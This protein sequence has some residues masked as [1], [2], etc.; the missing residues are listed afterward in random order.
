MRM[1]SRVQT[2]VRGRKRKARVLWVTNLAAPYRLP[3]W[4]RLAEEVDLQVELLE[5][6][7]RLAV[8]EGANRGSDWVPGDAG[9]P[10]REARTARIKRGEGRYYFLSDPRTLR[11]LATADA[12][13]L[14][15][16]E[17]PAYWQLLFAAKALRKRT[18]GFYESTLAT[19]GFATGPIAWAR[20][21]VFARLDGVV[22]PGPAAAQA[23]EAMGVDAA[24]IHVGFN[25]VD[26]AR[27]AQVRHAPGRE[28][29]HRFI[30]VGQLIPRK[31]VGSLLQAFADAAEPQDVLRIIGRGALESDLRSL[32]SRLGIAGRVS[33]QSFVPNSDMPA[34][35][36]RADTLVLPSSEEVWGLVVNEALAAG[37]QVVVTQN[38][39]VVP[40]VRDMEGVFIASGPADLGPSLRRARAQYSGRIAEPEIL[41]HTPEEF[42]ETFRD[43]II[44]TGGE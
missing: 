39:G 30:Y 29:A 16:W 33:W 42:A 37:L 32:A 7:E 34:E 1:V 35:F 43:A 11:R 14:G 31:E 40:S 44:Q 13:V 18:I 17:S 24:R 28:N 36:A 12:V 3:V 6:R 4:R 41:E 22:V 38:C 10:I 23:V 21:W 19:Q 25:A 8:D 2:D 26:S 15:G 27:F 5:P 20:R 9:F